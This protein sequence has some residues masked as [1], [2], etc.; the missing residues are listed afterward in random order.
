MQTFA[1]KKIALAVG[2]ALV[3]MAGATQAAGTNPTVRTGGIVATGMSAL[4]AQS[5]YAATGYAGPITITVYLQPLPDTVTAANSQAITDANL[6][7]NGQA[8][9]GAGSANANNDFTVTYGATPVYFPVAAVGFTANTVPLGTAA[10]AANAANAYAEA[11]FTITAV[12]GDANGAFRINGANL[13]YTK[14]S[15]ASPIVW[16]VVNVQGLTAAANPITTT[17]GAG[18]P[19]NT[20]T[21]A[22]AP[23]VA[24]VVP[25]PTMTTH[26][27]S[28]VAGGAKIDGLVIN[29]FSPISVLTHT[30]NYKVTGV[31]AATTG[32]VGSP[33]AANDVTTSTVGAQ[34][35]ALNTVL[36][37][38]PDTAPWTAA[39]AGDAAA[40]S[41]NCF[42]TGVTG[43]AVPFVVSL[44]PATLP[45]FLSIVN[46]A[47]GAP[48]KLSALPPN[49]AITDGAPPV[50]VTTA[51]GAPTPA[52]PGGTNLQLTFSEPMALIGQNDLREVLENVFIGSNSLGALVLNDSLNPTLTLSPV[53]A[54]QSTLIIN[55]LDGG[56][57]TP[58]STVTVTQGITFKEANDTGASAT[59]PAIDNTPGTEPSTGVYGDGG[60]VQLAGG[61]ASATGAVEAASVTAKAVTP[62]VITVAFADAECRAQTTAADPSKVGTIICKFPADRAI[63]LAS[64]LTTAALVNQIRVTV[65][66]N[67]YGLVPPGFPSAKD[68]RYQ[69]FPTAAQMTLNA[70]GTELKIAL[71][72]DLIYANVQTPTGMIVDYLGLV[73][74]GT[75][76][77]LVKASAAAVPV[78]AL[79]PT[80]L[81]AAGSEP[82]GMPLSA[83][84][85]TN[86]GLVTQSIIGSFTTVTDG[87]RVS[88]FLAHWVATP[89]ANPFATAPITG[90]VS[91]PASTSLAFDVAS[92]SLVN[93]TNYV[94]A[95]N[96]AIKPAQ[97]A[98]PGVSPDVPAVA[99]KPAP[100]YFVVKDGVAEAFFNS[101]STTALAQATIRSKLIIDEINV[102]AQHAGEVGSTR[103]GADGSVISGDSSITTSSAAA[104]ASGD[105]A[106]AAEVIRQY[107]VGAK[108]LPQ[109]V[110]VAAANAAAAANATPASVV[111][112]VLATI[113]DYKVRTSSLDPVSGAIT[114]AVTGKL[115]IKNAT[116]STAARGLV[117]D[118]FYN[119][120]GIVGTVNG[121]ANSFNL[122]LGIDPANANLNALKSPAKFVI[123]V[124]ESAETGEFTMLTSADAAAAN[125][126]PFSANLLTGSGARTTLAP[127]VL[128]NLKA[129]DEAPNAWTL[130]PLGNPAKKAAPSG[131]TASFDQMFVG[132]SG[133][134]PQSTWTNDGCGTDMALAMVGNKATAASEQGV[135]KSTLSTIT[136]SSYIA[137]ASAL[138][139]KNDCNLGTTMFVMQGTP[140]AAKLPAGWSLVTTPSSGTFGAAVTGVINVGSQTTAP[141]TWITGDTGAPPVAGGDPVFVYSKAGGAL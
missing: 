100:I 74:S 111:K 86:D 106:A 64:G 81:V 37:P 118:S 115:A 20:F 129:I 19:A 48:A 29:T 84:A 2:A 49:A 65:L 10:I 38:T 120:D 102:A 87:D 127:I 141:F 131:Y 58:T 79:K 41:T 8:V 46:P 12:A 73:P 114:G 1:K 31:P 78:P 126:V 113:N 23:A 117:I 35:G 92:T 125:F 108:I 66:S 67:D 122:L 30:T 11:T 62:A 3:L 42:N 83:S 45:T 95:Q 26:S 5:L 54:G 34:T 90:T 99:A 109:A 55:G 44:V 28:T 82:V 134:A 91:S 6:L 104:L 24:G 116:T 16:N 136:S 51:A 140:V 110:M 96:N 9:A 72:T 88:A 138:A 98:V 107:F 89:A 105:A 137:G 128:A 94:D 15:T 21:S 27:T 47:S 53:L 33:I 50:I 132:L 68:E 139:W 36:F 93:V 40:Y 76:G 70:A 63:S 32:C 57:L 13:E 75:E 133:G 103:T 56:E 4:Q 39:P 130:V 80:D 135:N 123:L 69:F 22:A 18:A 101:T 85:G 97:P 43:N 112:A 119:A 77:A 124:H 59:V 60:L 7:V 61:I 52:R 25:T 121:V 71:P 17:D 14:D